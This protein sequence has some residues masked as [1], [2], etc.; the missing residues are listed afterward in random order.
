[1]LISTGADG[2]VRL[3]DTKKGLKALGNLVGHEQNVVR[4]YLMYLVEG[5]VC[6]HEGVDD[7]FGILGSEYQCV[8]AQ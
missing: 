7:C 2:S 5:G 8:E 4:D 1:M 3:W 6:A